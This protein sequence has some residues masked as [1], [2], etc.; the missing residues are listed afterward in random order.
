MSDCVIFAIFL[1]LPCKVNAFFAWWCLI[2]YFFRNFAAKL[3]N[4]DWL[5]EGKCLQKGGEIPKRRIVVGVAF[6]NYKVDNI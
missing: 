1:F 2:E 6:Y 5:A 4:F 3:A